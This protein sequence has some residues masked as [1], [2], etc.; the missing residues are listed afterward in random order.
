MPKRILRGR[1][2][3][4]KA[5]KTITVVVERKKKHPLYHKIINFTKKFMA[6]DES[7]EAKEGDLV[8]I[9][10]SKP[11]SKRKTWVLKSVVEKAV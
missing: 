3:S 1:V 6:H 4:D 10:E 11:I 7:N 9:E 8:L 2:T 5:D